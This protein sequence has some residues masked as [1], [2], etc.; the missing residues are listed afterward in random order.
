MGKPNAKYALCGNCEKPKFT[1]VG[2]K[3][4]F[5]TTDFRPMTT[6]ERALY[7]RAHGLFEGTVTGRLAY[8][9]VRAK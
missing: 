6:K 1:H 4:L 7:V 2:A 8:I 3:C 5:S 9:G